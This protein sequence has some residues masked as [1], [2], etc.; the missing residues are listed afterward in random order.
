MGRSATETGRSRSARPAGQRN[1]T[2]AAPYFLMLWGAG[3][4]TGGAVLL[5]GTLWG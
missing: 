5:V 2:M 4:F 3:F 1:M